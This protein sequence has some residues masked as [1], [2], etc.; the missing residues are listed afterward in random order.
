MRLQMEDQPRRLRY[1]NSLG[2]SQNEMTHFSIDTRQA[3]NQH[4][5]STVRVEVETDEGSSSGH[6]FFFRRRSSLAGL[7]N[8]LS[9]T[10]TWSK[11]RRT[12]MV[13][14]TRP[15][16]E[17]NRLSIDASGG[18]RLMIS[19]ALDPSPDEAIDLCAVRLCR[20]KEPAAGNWSNSASPDEKSWSPEP[21]EEARYPAVLTVAIIGYPSALS[22]QAHN[23]PIFRRGT[24]ASHPAVDFNGRAEVV[25]DMACF[26]G[27]LGSPATSTIAT[28]SPRASLS[29]VLHA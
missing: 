27:S 23:L 28:G 22:D 5:F 3:A 4:L 24:S 7:R 15:R 13:F 26:P 9:R 12:H 25:I 11:A 18:S 2:G 19:R 21:N 14:H 16:Y 10:I 8:S 1:R 17:A 20:L 29:G 6:A